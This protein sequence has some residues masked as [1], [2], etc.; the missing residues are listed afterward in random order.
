[1]NQQTVVT[2]KIKISTHSEFAGL[3]SNKKYIKKLTIKISVRLLRQLALSQ[4]R[5]I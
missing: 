4:V 1:M 2:Y 3:Q 5:V